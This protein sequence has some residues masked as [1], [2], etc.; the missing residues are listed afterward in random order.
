MEGVVEEDRECTPE[1]RKQIVGALLPGI[2]P[3]KER[4]NV[5]QS[6]EYTQVVD[7]ADRVFEIKSE[8]GEKQHIIEN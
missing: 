6:V 4:Q 8:E 2:T 5:K 3:L 1:H 7:E